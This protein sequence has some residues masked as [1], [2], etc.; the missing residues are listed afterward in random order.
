MTAR[1]SGLRERAAEAEA[2]LA[3]VS[4]AEEEAK[5]ELR[6]RSEQLQDNAPL[7]AIRESV[8]RL[9]RENAVL[10]LRV[11]AARQLLGMRA[12]EQHQ[13]DLPNLH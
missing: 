2:E 6:D 12:K 9:E 13:E 1:L 5:S 4:A 7:L 3:R 11:G 10:G 8:L